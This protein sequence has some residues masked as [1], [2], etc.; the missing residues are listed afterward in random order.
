M[1]IVEC[2]N[3]CMKSYE[4]QENGNIGLVLAI[5]SVV[6]VITAIIYGWRGSEQTPLTG[7]SMKPLAIKTRET[8]W[9]FYNYVLGFF[10][11]LYNNTIGVL[12]GLISEAKKVAEDV[13]KNAEA[14]AQAKIEERAN[15][16][17]GSLPK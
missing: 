4:Q 11:W 15:K 14:K 13:V 17:L 12:P 1:N 10:G 3:N 6:G 9:W 5:V 2:V 8:F 16:S 7:E